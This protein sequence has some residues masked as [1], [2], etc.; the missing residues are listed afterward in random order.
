MLN[1]EQPP[2]TIGGDSFARLIRETAAEEGVAAIVLRVNSGGGSVFAS[3]VI[4]QEILNAKAKGLPVVVSMGSIAAS[5][6]YYISAEVDQIWATPAT[7]TGSIGVIAAFPTLE[8]L[9]DRL[10]VHTDGVGT[11]NLAGSLRMDRPLSPQLSASI[12]SSVENTYRNFVGLVA[13]GRGM[14]PEAVDRVAQGRVWSAPDALEEGLIDALGH[15][16]DAV[17]AAAQLANLGDYEVDYVGLPMS[18]RDQM[19]QALADRVG[20]LRLWT[21]SSTANAVSRLLK[22]AVD[23]AGELAQLNDPANLYMRCLACGAAN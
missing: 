4:R 8:K 3:E 21:G 13:S 19:M 12:T 14:T 2:G 10:G 18:P 20:S 22:P 1:G 5:G 15:L 17:R 9:F 11:T 16:G 23:A 6:A 7:I